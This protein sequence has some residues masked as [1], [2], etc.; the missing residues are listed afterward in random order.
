MKVEPAKKKE[1]PAKIEL[2]GEHSLK[3]A[4]PGDKVRCVIEGIVTKS[5]ALPQK[6]ECEWEKQYSTEIQIDKTSHEMMGEPLP[7][8]MRKR[9]MAPP[10]YSRRKIAHAASQ[11]E[12]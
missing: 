1:E 4:K 6:P 3:D 12:K 2:Y 11:G 8:I 9:P 10:P 5:C 7:R